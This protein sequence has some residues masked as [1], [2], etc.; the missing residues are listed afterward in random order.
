MYKELVKYDYTIV[1]LKDE[2]YTRNIHNASCIV[3]CAL[4][5]TETVGQFAVSRV[6]PAG[7]EFT[8]HYKS[9]KR[10]HAILCL[11]LQSVS[12]MA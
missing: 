10:C 3:L 11:N 6:S 5:C 4:A 2:F 12:P 1:T 7:H 8:L 9:Y